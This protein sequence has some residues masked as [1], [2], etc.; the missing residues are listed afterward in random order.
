MADKTHAGK[1]RFAIEGP[2][3]SYSTPWAV[4]AHGDTVYISARPTGGFVKISLHPV[5]GYRFA[6]TKEFHSRIRGRDPKLVSRDLIVWP[7]PDLTGKTAAV[8]VSL[9]FPTDLFWSNRPPASR[10]RRYVIFKVQDQGS[11]ACVKF[12]VS[13]QP[14]EI[15][16]PYLRTVGHPV[17]YWS[18]NGNSITLVVSK[19]SFDR[20]AFQQEYG[21]TDIVPLTDSGVIEHFGGPL[22]GIV[23]GEPRLGEPL[24][25]WEIGRAILGRHSGSG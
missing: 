19:A 12:F 6:H 2:D 15:L 8:V 9:C 21:V 23:W 20:S 22:S 16:D 5:G 7:Q 3:G 13:N 25:M 10:S 18:A 11:A 14:R 4:W 24:E 1:F 17:C